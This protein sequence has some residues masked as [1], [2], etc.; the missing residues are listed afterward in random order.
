MRQGYMVRARKNG[1]DFDHLVLQTSN[2]GMR[3]VNRFDVV[4]EFTEPNVEIVMK[5]GE[6]RSLLRVDQ[7]PAWW[8]EITDH[9]GTRWPVMC[10][11]LGDAK[12]IERW[13]LK[14]RKTSN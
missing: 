10:R 12:A 8:I 1:V 2:K 9:D 4:R 11:N 3:L 6:S 5:L 7:K 14:H 13:A